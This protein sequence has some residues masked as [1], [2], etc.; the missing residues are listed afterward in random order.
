M[1][2]CGCAGVVCSFSAPVSQPIW[3]LSG[4]KSNYLS[5]QILQATSTLGRFMQ[6][7]HIGYADGM[8]WYNYVGSDPVNN[9]DP[10]GLQLSD[11]CFDLSEAECIREQCEEALIC[12]EEERPDG[13][14]SG[15]NSLGSER[16]YP[17]RG[18]SEGDG[19]EPQ[20]KEQTEQ[21][22][23]ASSGINDLVAKNPALAKSIANI[24][25]LGA[26]N[27]REYGFVSRTVPR[28]WGGGNVSIGPTTTGVG[29][30]WNASKGFTVQNFLR[31]NGNAIVF[32]SHYPSDTYAPDLSP[33]DISNGDGFG[34]A[35]SVSVQNGVLYCSRSSR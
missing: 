6:T 10:S 30:L 24:D 32:H 22:N 25:R 8:N 20:S 23:C 26:A 31:L 21:D 7:D 11:R 3:L 16:E 29:G 35:M 28:M 18:N 13:F 9:V 2:G 1:P 33:A 34:E 17:G 4:R 15:N 27:R 14:G 12:V 5:V 19:E